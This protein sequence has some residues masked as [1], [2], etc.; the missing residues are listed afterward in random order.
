MSQSQ[1]RKISSSTKKPRNRVGSTTTSAPF[2]VVSDYDDSTR[3]LLS[4]IPSPELTVI[5]KPCHG[6]S[7]RLELQNHDEVTCFLNKIQ[8]KSSTLAVGLSQ[9]RLAIASSSSTQPICSGSDV[10]ELAQNPENPGTFRNRMLADI[11]YFWRSFVLI[12]T[13][14][15]LAPCLM[16]PDPK[17]RCAFCITL[18]AV[19]WMCEVI[20]LPATALL[21]IVLF[22]CTGILDAQTVAREFLNVSQSPISATLTEKIL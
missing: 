7:S 22:P 16:S 11:L 13:P 10:D 15:I 4:P 19:Y 1:N 6:F 14:M 2:L 5:C 8:S 21:P 17:Y 18:M 9:D 20:P 12:L 3:T